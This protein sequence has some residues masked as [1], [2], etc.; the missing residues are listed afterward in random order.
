M[1]CFSVSK[2]GHKEF[3]IIINA[4]KKEKERVCLQQQ[5]LNS[6]GASSW[7]V[8]VVVYNGL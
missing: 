1:K 3:L 4:V 8:T 7:W 2:R 5:F 6:L